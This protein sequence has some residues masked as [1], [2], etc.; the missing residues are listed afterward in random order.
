MELK[1]ILPD[2]S[3]ISNPL[4]LTG[5]ATPE[6]YE[7]ALNI[8]KYGENIDIFILY[9]VVPN[10]P[11]YRN[12]ERLYDLFSRNWNKTLVVV[13]AGGEYSKNVSRR[14]EEMGVPVI[15]TARRVINALDK[16]VEYSRWKNGRD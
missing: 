10:A 1:K 8:L 15:T 6:W 16:I 5:S 7:K 13:I 14:I 2:F 11:I 9:F 12:I 3:I 4:D